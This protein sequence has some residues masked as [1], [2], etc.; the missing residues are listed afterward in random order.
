MTNKITIALTR[1]E[2]ELYR[3][4]GLLEE[5]HKLYQKILDESTS[6]GSSLEASLQEKVGKLEKELS[7]LEIDLSEVI[8][9][10][11]LDI[12]RQGW[13]DSHSPTDIKICA[14]ALNNIGLYEAA[15]EEYGKLINLSQ[16]AADYLDELTDCITKIYAPDT[17]CNAVETII[18]RY[19]PQEAKSTGL[20]VGIAARLSRRGLD[21][22][23]LDLFQSARAI[24]PLPDKVEFF[25]K[26]IQKRYEQSKN[27]TDDN[28]SNPTSAKEKGT[29]QQLKRCLAN[30]I[31]RLQGLIRRLR[32]A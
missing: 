5:A 8:S 22:P 4:H 24:Q 11:E 32:K 6:L 29:T 25:A 17:I 27:S 13:G 15:I 21:Q 14:S 19:K 20:L 12:L 1:R 16:P 23:A 2:A 9:E 31:A 3:S 7:D 30:Q 10:Q 26:N 28:V 18:D